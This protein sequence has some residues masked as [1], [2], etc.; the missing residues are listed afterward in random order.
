MYRCTIV[1]IHP[2]LNALGSK[3]SE[4]IY[5]RLGTRDD[6]RTFLTSGSPVFPSW[7]TPYAPMAFIDS[8][9]T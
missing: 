4:E 3:G 2:P 7:L 8:L 9:P 5:T 1:Q 6:V